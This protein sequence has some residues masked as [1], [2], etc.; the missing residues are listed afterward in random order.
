MGRHDEAL[1]AL[2][3][4]LAASPQDVDALLC[5]AKVLE[6]LGRASEIE[7]T[8]LRALPAGGQ[9]VAAELAIYYMRTGEYEKA[10][11]TAEEALATA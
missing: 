3:T 4:V 7:A 8:L 10:R 1:I 6:T 2:D 5:R 9:R 11:A